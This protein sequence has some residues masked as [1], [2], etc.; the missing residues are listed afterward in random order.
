MR[1]GPSRVGGAWLVLL[2]AG[3]VGVAVAAGWWVLVALIAL[4]ATQVLAYRLAGRVSGDSLAL[5]AIG[6]ALAG[7]FARPDAL[8]PFLLL[9]LGLAAGAGTVGLVLAR[10]WGPRRPLDEARSPS[11][12]GTLAPSYPGP[13]ASGTVRP[14]DSR[15]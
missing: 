12:T 13:R 8:G 15:G 11:P 2:M 9:G 10:Y 14:I 1:Q 3:V 5:G 6:L 7:V 4:V